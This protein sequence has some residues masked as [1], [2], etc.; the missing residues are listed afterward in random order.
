[1]SVRLIAFNDFHGNLETSGLTLPWPDPAKPDR[2]LRLAAGGAAYLA[3]TVQRAARRCGQQP[4]HQQ[5]RPDR[6]HAAGFGPVPAR[7]HHRRANRPGRGHRHSRQPRI[8]RRQG[9]TAARA[10]RRLPAA[11]PDGLFV[12]CA[13]GQHTGARFPMF[14]ANVTAADGKTLF[15]PSVVRS[16]GGVKIGFIGAVTRITPT[17]VVPSGVAGLKFTTRPPPSTPKPRA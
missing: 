1:V 8:R 10:A 13:L 2:A 6:R 3:G 7:I 4:G 17:I 12:S 15:P 5:R 16:F 9:R 14:A 11:K